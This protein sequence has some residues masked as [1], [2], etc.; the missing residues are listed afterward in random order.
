MIALIVTCTRCGAEYSPEA[1]ELLRGAW[2]LCPDC[3]SAP[4]AAPADQPRDVTPENCFA[5][6][7]VPA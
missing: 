5:L 1:K 7:G 4:P 6:K 2:R 3:R